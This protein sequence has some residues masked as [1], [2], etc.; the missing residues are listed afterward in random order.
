MRRIFGNKLFPS[1]K[2]ACFNCGSE[3][4][5]EKKCPHPV[6]FSRAAASQI[7][8]LQS[9]NN[10]NA[11]H[12]VLAHLCRELDESFNANDNE[13]EEGNNEDVA[14][15]EEMLV[16]DDRDPNMECNPGGDDCENAILM[17]NPSTQTAI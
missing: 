7:R 2:R 10:C 9:N 3:S 8:N 6:N 4:H 11:V 15:F 17:K 1:R 14:V 13:I 12:V 16:S 5:L